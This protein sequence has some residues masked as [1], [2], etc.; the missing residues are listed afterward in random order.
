M[1][2]NQLLMPESLERIIVRG[3]DGPQSGCDGP[4]KTDKQREAE[5]VAKKFEGIFIH[6][7]FKQIKETTFSEPAEDAEEEQDSTGEGVEDMYWSFMADAVAKEGGLGLWKQVYRQLLSREGQGDLPG[8][9]GLDS[10]V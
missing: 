6:Q 5:D 9:E 4:A 8:Q 2:I 10:R 3:K 1:E 7:I